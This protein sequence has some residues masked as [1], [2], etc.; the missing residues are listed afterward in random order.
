MKKWAN[1]N[2]Y[3]IFVIYQIVGAIIFP[4]ILSIYYRN[5]KLFKAYYAGLWDGVK[6]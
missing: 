5:Y 6:V 2:D 1:K 4:L 3:S